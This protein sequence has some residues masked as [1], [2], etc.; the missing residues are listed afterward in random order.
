MPPG[1]IE[2]SQKQRYEK[3]INELLK[4]TPSRDPVDVFRLL[5]DRS[6]K[7][8]SPTFQRILTS[9]AARHHIK[10]LKEVTRVD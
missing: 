7:L 3:V 8:D 2:T 9:R 4:L 5:S 10:N 6:G 1:A